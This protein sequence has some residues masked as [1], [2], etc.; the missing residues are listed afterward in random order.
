MS[1]EQIVFFWGGFMSNWHKSP[2]VVNDQHYNC[3]EQYMMAEKAR[4]FLD[5]EV[6]AKI[7]A[8][9]YPKAQKEFGRKVRNYD[10]T[11]WGELRYAVVLQGT[12]AKYQQNEELK[13]EL[14]ET[15]T[16]VLAEASPYDDL[17]GIGMAESNPNA[18]D[19]SKWGQNLLGKVLMEARTLL[20]DQ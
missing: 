18:K 2:F 10:E 4:I 14:L 11:I 17:W 8:S 13:K 16:A 15:G 1:D 7:L 9:P 5:E 6:R 20:R 3:M 19:Q 12:M